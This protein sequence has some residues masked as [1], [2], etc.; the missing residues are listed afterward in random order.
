MRTRAFVERELSRSRLG[1]P[2]ERL[3][4]RN[5]IGPHNFV[6]ALSTLAIRTSLQRRRLNGRTGRDSQS[7]EKGTEVVG[8]WDK[9]TH[10]TRGQYIRA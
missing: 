10:K 9:H 3:C 7:V 1:A 6:M 4:L 5:S 8:V 2:I